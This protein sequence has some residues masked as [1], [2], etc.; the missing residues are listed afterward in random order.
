M[1]C[2]LPPLLPAPP[3]PLTGVV[4][5]A[6]DHVRVLV[7]PRAGT[8]SPPDSVLHHRHAPSLVLVT[9]RTVLQP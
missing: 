3:L 7:V 2:I 8:D 4:E 6:T 5:L 1:D 9:K